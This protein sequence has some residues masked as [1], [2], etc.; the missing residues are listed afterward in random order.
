MNKN[1]RWKIVLIVGVVALSVWSFYPPSQKV[2]LGLDLRGGVHLIMRVQTEAALRIETDTAAERLREGLGVAAVEYTSLEVTSPTEFVVEGVQDDQA[3]RQVAV[4]ADTVFARSPGAGSYTYTMRPNIATQLREEAVTQ[5]QQ[6]IERRVNELGVAEPIVARQGADD[7]ILVQLPG[8]TDV[9]RAKEVI[10]RTALLELKLVEQGPFLSEEAAMQAVG[11]VVPPDMEIVS[12]SEDV[13]ATGGGTPGTVYYIVRRVAPV[14]GRDLRTSRPTLDENN[15]PAVSF[16]FNQDGAQRFGQF[17]EQN[18][19]RGLAVMLD[20]RVFTAPTIQSRIADEG[21]ITGSFTQQEAQ[22]L[23]LV[24]RTGALPAP[25]DVLEERTVG[26]TLGRESIR[27]G[28]TASLGG[29]TLVLIFILLYYKRTG[30]NAVVSILVNLSI[31]LGMMAYLG[32]T[33]TLPGIA[34]F[35]LT[36]GIGVDSNV[37]IFERIKEELATAKGVRAAVNSG[38]DRVWWTIVDTHVASLISAMFL[39]QFGTGPIR[40]FATTLTIGLLANVFTAV[41]VSRTMFE[42]VL[43]RRQ[44]QAQVLSI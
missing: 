23:S 38:F 16:T 41:F 42:L 33:M 44:Q 39:F 22:D 21:R 18:I 5:A 4:E 19:G 27:A 25:M 34:G 36:I 14:T 31:L 3:F 9:D 10:G 35:I 28:V 29:L 6:T 13:A 1:L 32:A 24:L 37:L 2:N 40:G 17:T 43:S 7:Q 12:G 26:P 8:V 11:D 30:L 20:N 15:L